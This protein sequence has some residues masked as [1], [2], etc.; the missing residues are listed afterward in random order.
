MY[1]KLYMLLLI[2]INSP[3]KHFKTSLFIDHHERRQADQGRSR[4]KDRN[5]TTFPNL[6]Y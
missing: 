5:P 4:F 1:D 3:E 6:N 2:Y